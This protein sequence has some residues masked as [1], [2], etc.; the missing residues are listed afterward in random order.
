MAS[1]QTS[2]HRSQT[3]KSEG[4]HKPSVGPSKSV[5][6]QTTP[7]SALTELKADKSPN[8]VSS[9]KHERN[10]I[11]KEND[12]SLSE[13]VAKFEASTKETKKVKINTSKITIIDES[14]AS[15]RKKSMTNTTGAENSKLH[16]SN[17]NPETSVSHS[18]ISRRMSKSSLLPIELKS[19]VNTTIAGLKAAIGAPTAPCSTSTDSSSQA[20][21]PPVASSAGAATVDSTSGKFAG[22]SR[23]HAPPKLTRQ[24]SLAAM[25]GLVKSKEMKDNVKKSRWLPVCE[26]DE[27]NGSGSTGERSHSMSY[28]PGQAGCYTLR[29]LPPLPMCNRRSSCTGDLPGGLQLPLPRAAAVIRRKPAPTAQLPD[30]RR[31][32]LTMPYATLYGSWQQSHVVASPNALELTPQQNILSINK[33]NQIATASVHSLSGST[34]TGQHSFTD[35]ANRSKDSCATTPLL[36]S[37]SQIEGGVNERANLFICPEGVAQMS[38]LPETSNDIINSE[39]CPNSPNSI[40]LQQQYLYQRNY[41]MPQLMASSL[42]K[43]PM[44]DF[45]SE[46]RASLDIAHFL[47]SAVMLLDVQD[48]TLDGITDMLLVKVLEQDEPMCSVTEAKSILFTTDTGE[49]EVSFACC[50]SAAIIS[51]LWKLLCIIYL[52]LVGFAFKYCDFNC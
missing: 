32:S 10:K 17:S 7:S 34:I 27:G 6:P 41:V 9:K 15:S 31:C 20:A 11:K 33:A 43:V 50:R 13:P 37:P 51:L 5:E 29:P 26:E 4:S 48:T 3:F 12:S 40:T 2:V 1:P 30:K 47:Q 19:T 35:A 42:Q 23:R 14:P 22:R 39:N 24:H 16:S 18:S 44:K 36:L 21:A 52:I 25:L 38:L 8:D 49:Y 46:V 45:G 28:M